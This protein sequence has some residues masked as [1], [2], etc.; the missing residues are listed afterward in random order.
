MDYLSVVVGG[1]SMD[2]GSIPNDIRVL[3]IEKQYTTD[4]VSA[5]LKLLHYGAGLGTLKYCLQR[6]AMFK[7]R[8]MKNEWMLKHKLGLQY[9]DEGQSVTKRRE[10]LKAVIKEVPR[11]SVKLQCK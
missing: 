10:L 8:V 9:W 2:H 11:V 1:H 4:A 3:H 6:V 5:P 7:E